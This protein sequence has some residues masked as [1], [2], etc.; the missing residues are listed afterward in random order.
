MFSVGHAQKLHTYQGLLRDEWSGVS[1]PSPDGGVGAEAH[2]AGLD[3]G[4]VTARTADGAAV[5]EPAPPPPHNYIE[6]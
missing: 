6:I 1:D 2:A 5:G 4:V 3:G